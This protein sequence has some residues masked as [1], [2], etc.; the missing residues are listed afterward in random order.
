M[1][2]PFLS[3][4]SLARWSTV[5]T[6]DTCETR[7]HTHTH[8]TSALCPVTAQHHASALMHACHN[9]RDD[10]ETRA[11]VLHK[12]RCSTHRRSPCAQRRKTLSQAQ[13]QQVW[14]RFLQFTSRTGSLEMLTIHEDGRQLG[15]RH[16]MLYTGAERA[17]RRE[18]MAARRLVRAPS[19]RVCART[20][21]VK[22]PTP[23]RTPT[24]GARGRGRR[25]TRSS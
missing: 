10:T 1:C 21:L 2:N 3:F 9:A 17:V 16:T 19:T 12:Q 6:I 22:I 24:R 13:A 15:V 4:P 14:S 5:C 8:M 18:A 23:P 11:H 7:P 25:H 20:S